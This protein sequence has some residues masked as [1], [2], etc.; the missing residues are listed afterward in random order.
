MD[1]SFSTGLLILIGLAI[2]IIGGAV[3][4]KWWLMLTFVVIWWIFW[5]FFVDIFFG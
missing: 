4:L 1:K 5:Q 2:I 3:G